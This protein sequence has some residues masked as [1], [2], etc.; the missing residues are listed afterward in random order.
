MN[1]FE[2]RNIASDHID[3]TLPKEEAARA[4]AHLAAS[5][6]SRRRFEHYREIIGA[7]QG[8]ECHGLPAALRRAPL[9]AQLPLEG[10]D[11]EAPERSAGSAAQPSRRWRRTPWFVRTSV[12]GIGIALIILAVVAMVPR[13]SRLYQKS[14]DRRLAPFEMAELTEDLEV[15][16]TTETANLLEEE[17]T[18]EEPA[19]ADQVADQPP[20]EINGTGEGGEEDEDVVED[21]HVG[22]Y[23]IWRFNIRTESP[24]ELKPKVI[25][26]LAELEIPEETP[27]YHGIEAPG[28]IQFN[29]LVDKSYIPDL[30]RRIQ[31]VAH[32]N[33]APLDTSDTSKVLA[34][35]FF[36]YK[37][38]ARWRS[39][40]HIPRGKARVVI[41]LGRM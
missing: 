2:W 31:D 33:T 40:R 5:D 9:S 8:L 25:D 30:K 26:A 23:E 17:L 22:N 37:S 11:G 7:I 38:K 35:T 16:E 1:E 18:P 10:S 13:I 4:D 41:W 34:G 3:G 32:L 14:F 28:G 20:A 36:W 27:G 29:M 12:E 6:S 21:I 24:R 39:R 19:G 15:Q